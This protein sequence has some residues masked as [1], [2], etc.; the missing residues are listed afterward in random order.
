[1]VMEM[2]I[3]GVIAFTLSFVGACVLFVA[4]GRR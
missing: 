4:T 3:L 2:E 1:M